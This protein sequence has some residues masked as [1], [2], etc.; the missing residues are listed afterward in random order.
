[1]IHKIVEESVKEMDKFYIPRIEE[2]YE[3]M[4]CL[5]RIEAREGYVV[6]HEVLQEHLQHHY[7]PKK[8]ITLEVMRSV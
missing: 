1:M 8:E 4:Y 5:G 6:A 3:M 7:K 2:K